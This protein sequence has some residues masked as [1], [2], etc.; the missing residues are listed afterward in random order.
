[1]MKATELGNG[2]DA[3][4]FRPLDGPRL[5]CILRQ[6]EVSARFMIVFQ[7]SLH[8]LIQRSS[9]NTIMWSKHS[10]RMEPITRST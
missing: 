8:V 2:N 1:M 9:P 10:R 7:E 6:R 3:P 5:R 4:D